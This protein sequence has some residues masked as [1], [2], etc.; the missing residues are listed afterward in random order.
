MPGR[1]SIHNDQAFKADV[2][3][4]LGSFKDEVQT[5]VPNYNIAPTHEAPILTNTKRYTTAHFGLIPSWAKGRSQMQINARCESVF[6]KVTF[7]E[8][9]KFRR[10]ILMVNGYYEWLKGSGSA[11]S[12]PYYISSSTSDYFAFAGL[13]E[14]WYDNV[15]GK[16]VLSCALLTTEPNRFVEEVHDRMPVIL[17]KNS[18]KTWIDSKS[19]YSTLNKLY[20]P[21]PS[22]EMQMHTVSNEVNSVRNNSSEC[23]KEA[24][25]VPRQGSLFGNGD[26]S[27]V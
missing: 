10:C 19:G 12:V 15:E 2:I 11:K 22:N 14:E 20:I 3:Q 5:L 13:Y 24:M 8:A 16:T 25:L 1:L 4:T 26:F 23:I 18:W 27:P 21:Y 17:A 9:Y 7:K 6:E